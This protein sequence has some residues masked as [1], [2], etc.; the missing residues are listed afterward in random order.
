LLAPDLMAKPSIS[1]FF[2]CYND[3][4]TIGALVLDVEAVLRGLTDDYQIIVVNDG[5]RD[6]S[7]EV[8]R[9]LQTRVDSLEVV[10]HAV[11]SGYGAALRSG[12]A[13]ATKELIF[14]T[15]G[16][17]QYDV[18][19]LPLLLV[20]LS[21][22][23]DF[24]NGIKMTRQD[25]AYRVFVGNLHK[26][27]TRWMLW[28]PVIDVDCDFRLIRKSIIDRIRLTSSSGSICAELVKKSER[29]GAGFREVSVHHY[30][31]Q[32]GESQFFTPAKIIRTYVDLTRLWI[33]LMILDRGNS[34]QSPVAGR[35]SP[36]IS[37]PS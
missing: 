25:P 26:F 31:R 21:D 18:K 15:D 30:A 22:D 35:Q 10:T 8:L 17:G 5:S 16:D 24:V 1:V 9:E 6:T 28:L 20:L 37:R 14:Y 3:A 19:E 4:A 23:V 29:A 32:S 34:R 12:F 11:N 2:P 36:V 7:A 33:R 13:H 27:L